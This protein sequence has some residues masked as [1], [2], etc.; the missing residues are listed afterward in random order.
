MSKVVYCANCGL[1]LSIIRKAVKSAGVVIDMVEQHEC[2]EV[3]VEP[4][5]KLIDIPIFEPPKAKGKFAT[6][7]EELSPSP[8]FP[9]PSEL[10]EKDLR[11]RRPAKDVK[12]SAP[13]AIIDQVEKVDEPN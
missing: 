9:I 13:Q 8:H 4:D 12:S 7:V 1:R 5:L 11:D 10:D 2:L 3:P 6:R